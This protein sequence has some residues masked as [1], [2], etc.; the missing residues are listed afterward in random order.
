MLNVVQNTLDSRPMCTPRCMK[1]P[2]DPTNSKGEVRASN[3]EILKAANKT[4]LLDGCIC[5]QRITIQ[6]GEIVTSRHG[7]EGR[8]ALGH[9]SMP[10]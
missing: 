1:K 5:V 3:G 2:T 7:S 9:I 10:K 8:F 6:T 4:A